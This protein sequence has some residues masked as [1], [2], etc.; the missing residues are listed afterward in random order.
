LVEKCPSSLTPE[1]GPFTKNSYTLRLNLQPEAT[2][3]VGL[4]GIR[5]RTNKL[6][7]ACLE[8][9]GSGDFS[10]GGCGGGGYSAA[11]GQQLPEHIKS[12]LQQMLMPLYNAQAQML[13]CDQLSQRLAAA[14]ETSIRVEWTYHKFVNTIAHIIKDNFPQVQTVSFDQNGLSTL[15]AFRSMSTLCPSIRNLSLAN[16]EIDS[17][18]ELEAFTGL[19]LRELRLLGNPVLS[20]EGADKLAFHQK[21]RGIFPSLAL[22][23]GE[24]PKS[25][26]IAFNIPVP[27][28]LPAFK[29]NFVE[30]PGMEGIVKQFVTAF[31]SAYD[32]DRNSLLGVYLDNCYFSLTLPGRK[33]EDSGA[34]SS[35]G[36]GWKGGGRFRV[37]GVRFR[38]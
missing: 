20:T 14:N 29:G 31:F 12:K 1:P 2:A 37:L 7:I 16:N 23:D 4:S 32:S 35:A 30:K 21:I 5:Y 28:S 11:A 26:K 15:S 38:V 22:L 13:L 36:G 24:E 19:Q 17:A 9:A 18:N 10:R 8:A 27:K 34:A 6:E 3:L 25:L 33:K